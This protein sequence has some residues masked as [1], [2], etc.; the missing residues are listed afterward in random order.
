MFF[1]TTYY[2]STTTFCSNELSNY[3]NFS[4]KSNVSQL[5]SSNWRVIHPTLKSLSQFFLTK[6]NFLKKIDCK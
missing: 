6:I 1:L 3:S 2:M 4:C 5:I